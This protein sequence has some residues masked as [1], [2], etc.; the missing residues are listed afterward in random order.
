M[1]NFL[2]MGLGNYVVLEY[3]TNDEST[4]QII[5]GS[6]KLFFEV[7][8]FKNGLGIDVLIEISKSKIYPHAFKL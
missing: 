3:I 1:D 2:Y 6:W 5:D 4:E 7:S 8:C